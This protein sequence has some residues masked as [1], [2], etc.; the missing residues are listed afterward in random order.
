MPGPIYLRLLTASAISVTISLTLCRATGAVE[1]VEGFL[2]ALRGKGYYDMA[3]AYLER[4]SETGRLDDEFRRRYGYE[5]GS[6][7]L[8]WARTS[9]DPVLR[10]RLTEQ[11]LVKLKA[12]VESNKGDKLKTAANAR[13]AEALLEHGRLLVSRAE[14]S[15]NREELLATARANFTEA[16]QFFAA[17]EKQRLAEFENQAATA[18][19]EKRNQL[20]API[21]E[22]R[23]K[24]G[25]ATSDLAK[26]YDAASPEAK[27]AL[28]QGIDRYQA[29]YDKYASDGF[30]A[31]YAARVREAANYLALEETD[32]ALARLNDV[33]SLDLRN[34]S[35]RDLVLT[36]GYLIALKA[37]L[38]KSDYK[39]AIEKSEAYIASPS[40]SEGRRADWLE[41]QYLLATAFAEQSQSL[42]P[43][44]PQRAK[45]EAESRKL[46]SQVIKQKSDVQNDA[47]ALLGKLGR[48]VEPTSELKSFPE[49]FE[50]ATTAIQDYSAARFASDSVDKN[51]AAES[52]RLARQALDAREAA[53]SATHQAIKLADK[54]TDPGQLNTARFYLCYLHWEYGQ[55]E[56]AERNDSSHYFDAAVLGDFLARRFPDHAN[57]R[58]AMAIALASYQRIRQSVAQDVEQ[59]AQKLGKNADD[60]RAAVETAT[61]DWSSKIAQLAELGIARWP[62]TDEAASAT[63]IL[64]TL[65]VEKQDFDGALKFID[66]LKPGSPRRSDTE[67]RVGRAIWSQY[68]RSKK[69]LAEAA[70]NSPPNDP[71]AE[72]GSLAS[73]AS[74]TERPVA[75]PP[76]S[77]ARDEKQLAA[78]AKQAQSLLESGLKTAKERGEVDRGVVVAL[79]TLV[80][81]YVGTSQ[82]EL[83][84][85]WLEDEKIGLLT[86]V[87]NKDEAADIEGLLFDAYRLA[88]RAYIAVKPQQLEKALATMNA[89]EKISGDDAKGREM[90]TAVYIAMGRDLQQEIKQLVA[91]GDSAE[92]ATLSTAFEAFL[93][94]LA[95]RD[96]GNTFNSLFWVADTYSELGSGVA[97]IA[98]T[99]DAKLSRNYFQQAVTTFEKILERNK[100]DASFMPEKYLPLVQMRLAKAYRGAGDVD[101]AISL[102][103]KILSQKPNV[104]DLQFEA[105]YSIQETAEHNREQAA[106][107]YRLA[108]LGG[109][110]G[111]LRNIW[112]WNSLAER[113]RSQQER[114]R[115]D[116]TDPAKSEQLEQYRQRYQEARYNSVFCTF[117]LA[118]ITSNEKEKARLIKVAKQGIW[119]VYAVV[120]AELGGGEWK[121]KNDRLLKSIQSALGEPAIG[122]S[123]F[124]R[125]K[126]EQ[127]QTAASK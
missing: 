98:G 110:K 29:L 41:L 37:W 77:R 43:G 96:S 55:A 109:D 103:A 121:T 2:N 24:I 3:A 32:K 78:L 127:A 76:P 63:A 19:R 67:L 62:D 33:L 75:S 92:V 17:V 101:K 51:N 21:L 45:L 120:D 44:D 57:A 36:P 56:S 59:A 94:R 16:A 122:L 7:L 100:E 54:K 23:L 70:N 31:A 34:E 26:T 11:A 82:P 88:L 114:M 48:S 91:Q 6:V 113:I 50:K 49:A 89:L 52:E 118:G 116:G 39:T 69:A 107:Y 124:E 115:R 95:T 15:R 40:T 93:K 42:K 87:N 25:D 71:Q 27:Q 20:G 99:A 97:H 117:A 22:A 53:F 47:R 105:A 5:L 46:I 14:R 9:A 85:P 18:D 104:L 10:D 66:K 90:L 61:A 119:S 13:I 30:V 38:K 112:G 72:S 65:A 64:A 28:K 4:V 123:E 108:V 8:D 35:L 102:L 73:P 74:A 58:Q 81:S 83:A 125:R 106:K 12:Y 68:L 84:I 80:Q 1:P 111:D 86:L 60:I 126:R 79:W